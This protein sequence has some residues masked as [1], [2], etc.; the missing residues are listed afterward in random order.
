MTSTPDDMTMLGPAAQHK[1]KGDRPGLLRRLHLALRDRMPDEW[2][3]RRN[4]YHRFGVY[5]DLKNPQT[6]SEKVTWLKLNGATPLHRRCADKIEVRPWVAERIGADYLIR[7]LLMTDDPD[8]LTPEAIPDRAF[9]VKATHDTG[10]VKICTDRESFDWAGCRDTM[11]RAMANRF[12]LR[13]RERHYRDIPPRLIVEEMLVP[14]D[15]EVGLVD[16][17]VHC[18]HGEPQWIECLVRRPEAVYTASHGLDWARLP[19]AQIADA[20][21]S[22]QIPWDLPRP[23][24][25]DEML[26]IAR[27]ISAPFPLS[28]VDMYQVGGQVLFGE[29]T[30][31][32]AAGLERVEY[33]DP[34]AD[35]WQLD[36]ELGARLDMDRM[37][38]QLAAL[39]GAE[40]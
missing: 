24:L 35:P 34:A 9:V 15:P 3:V 5:P 27:S 8:A 37:R 23:A 12:W 26:R 11:R 28:R 19:W 18:F 2:V 7:A 4:Y 13:Q 6:L 33:T 16:Y 25:L 40:S 22:Q 32:P 31:T 14:D 29:I 20:T 21:N 17:K 39:R 30:F 36:E 38:T 10:S 1:D